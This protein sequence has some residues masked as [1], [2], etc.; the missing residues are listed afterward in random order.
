VASRARAIVV[1]GLVFKAGLIL[2]AF[3]C[4]RLAPELFASGAHEGNFRFD[5]EQGPFARMLSTW[6]AQWYLALAEQGYADTHPGGAAF[7]PLCRA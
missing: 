1:G 3:A 6:D 5:T 7:F 2:L 4:F